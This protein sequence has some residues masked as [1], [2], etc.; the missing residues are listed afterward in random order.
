MP[1]LIGKKQISLT[2]NLPLFSSL[3]FKVD[4]VLSVA[5]EVKNIGNKLFKSQDWKAAVSKYNKALR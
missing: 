3:C 1:N 5:E 2:W 4:Q